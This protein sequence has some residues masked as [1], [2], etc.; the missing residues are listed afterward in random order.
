[1]KKYLVISIVLL[2]LGCSTVGNRTSTF[3]Y[4]SDK[5]EATFD[6]RTCEKLTCKMENGEVTE[7]TFDRQKE[8][9]LSKILAIFTIMPRMEVHAD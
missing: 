6:G 8:S 3:T 5:K 7:I 9:L 2:T 1:M 4:D